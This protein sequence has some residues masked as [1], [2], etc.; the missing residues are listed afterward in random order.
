MTFIGAGIGEV[1]VFDNKRRNHL[2]PNVAKIVP[3][4]KMSKYLMYYFM[5]PTGQTEIFQ[6]MKAVAQPSLSMETIRKVKVPLPPLAE[7]KHIVQKLEQ[8]LPLCEKLK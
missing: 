6:F 3:H 4:M 7:Q 5:S 1:A 8:I 2:A